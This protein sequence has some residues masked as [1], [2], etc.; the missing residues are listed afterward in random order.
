MSPE[1]VGVCKIARRLS[2]P[3]NNVMVRGYVLLRS[4]VVPFITT[5]TVPSQHTRTS[6]RIKSI[7][8]KS[9]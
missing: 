3:W 1:I 2:Y 6:L 4:V 8:T 7:V 9:L 5:G